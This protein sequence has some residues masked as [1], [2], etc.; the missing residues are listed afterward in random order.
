MRQ[1]W[2][3]ALEAAYGVIIPEN[4]KGAAVNVQRVR[5]SIGGYLAKYIS[6]G[7]AD[8]QQVVESYGAE[9]LPGKWYTC[10]NEMLAL[11]HQSVLQRIGADIYTLMECLSSDDGLLVRW[12]S[13]QYV[14]W[15][16]IDKLWVAW[17]GWL[18]PRGMES[19]VGR[20]SIS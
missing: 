11:F 18:T 14:P 1:A 2:Y 10:T 20:N 15:K 6:K 4:E 13:H 9:A 7:V 3:R 17:I 12:G 19:I 8:V 16:G 5:K